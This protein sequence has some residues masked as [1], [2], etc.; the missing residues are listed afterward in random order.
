LLCLGDARVVIFGDIKI[1]YVLRVVRNGDLRPED[2]FFAK[3]FNDIG[4]RE[5]IV[6]LEL[7]LERVN[8]IFI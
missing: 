1:N 6:Y 5:I 3:Y 8:D 2:H 7:F 4:M